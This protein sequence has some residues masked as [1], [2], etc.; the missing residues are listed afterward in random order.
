MDYE[1][2]ELYKIKLEEHLDYIIELG[3]DF[4]FERKMIVIGKERYDKR[5]DQFSWQRLCA[6]LLK[7]RY[8]T[9]TINYSNVNYKQIIEEFRQNEYDRKMNQLK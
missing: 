1:I 9:R 3:T 4:L 5:G 8:I 7:K 2:S 6:F